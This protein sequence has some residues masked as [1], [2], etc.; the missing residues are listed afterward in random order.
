MRWHH[1]LEPNISK[2]HQTRHEGISLAT[3][4]TI[5]VMLPWMLSASAC[6]ATAVPALFAASQCLDCRSLTTSL[7]P[8]STQQ[9]AMQ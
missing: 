1:S 9:A 5:D 2:G 3:P 7:P 6:T 8:F 4:Q